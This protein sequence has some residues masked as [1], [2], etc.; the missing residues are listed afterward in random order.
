M[1]VFW[2]GLVV[3]PSINPDR[4]Q[5]QEVVGWCSGVGAVE[6]GEWTITSVSYILYTWDVWVMLSDR[7]LAYR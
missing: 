3:V 7:L 2:S 4:E 6:V 5:Y 1:L